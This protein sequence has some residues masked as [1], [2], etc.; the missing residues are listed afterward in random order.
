[1]QLLSFACVDCKRP[2]RSLRQAQVGYTELVH[3]AISVTL[4]LT[5]TA[6]G[7]KAV[8]FTLVNRPSWAHVNHYRT[9]KT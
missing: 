7:G 3:C 2:Y 6:H 9:P 5:H 1:M 4:C 8:N